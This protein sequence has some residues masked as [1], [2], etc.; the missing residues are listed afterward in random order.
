MH[1]IESSSL[2]L[3]S[4]LCYLLRTCAI[5]NLDL[6]QGSQ[7]IHSAKHSKDFENG[8]LE[9]QL[10]VCSS[11]FQLNVALEE[12]EKAMEQMSEIQSMLDDRV[13]DLAEKS[14]ECDELNAKH[15]ETGLRLLQTEE[16]KSR[17]EEKLRIEKKDVL[18]DNARF[19]DEIIEGYVEEL[20]R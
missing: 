13:K 11:Y 15:N 8:L 1:G 10:N 14:K 9:L 18:V 16:E 2:S 7:S 3:I 12:K 4:I 17:L 6:N 5:T 20:E 19:D